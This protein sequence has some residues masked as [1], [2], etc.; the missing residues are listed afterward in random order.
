VA[1]SRNLH[2]GHHMLTVWAIPFSCLC[3]RLQARS[4]PAKVLGTSDQ[5]PAPGP[6]AG[7]ALLVHVHLLSGKADQRE[8]CTWGREQR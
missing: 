2:I 4:F 6:C 7:I 8:H 5:R 1:A 3:Q